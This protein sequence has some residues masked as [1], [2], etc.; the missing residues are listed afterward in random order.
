TGSS[1]GV[2]VGLG[3]GSAAGSVT[4]N[5]APSVSFAIQLTTMRS[6]P[7]VPLR[8]DQSRELSLTMGIAFTRLNCRIIS[9]FSTRSETQTIPELE[10]VGHV[11]FCMVVGSHR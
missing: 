1:M 3:A 7:S 9:I 11:Y 8:L 6:G 2:G 5:R 4:A 10:L